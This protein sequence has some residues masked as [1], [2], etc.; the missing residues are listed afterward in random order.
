MSM[1]FYK[2]KNALSNSKINVQKIKENFSFISQHEKIRNINIK[3]KLKPAKLYSDRVRNYWV[4]DFK[5]KLG[6]KVKKFFPINPLRQIQ[7]ESSYN[8]IEKKENEPKTAVK[9][10]KNTAVKILGAINSLIKS[11]TRNKVDFIEMKNYLMKIETFKLILYKAE[12]SITVVSNVV[13]KISRTFANKIIKKFERHQD[14]ELNNEF[15]L[16]NRDL[17]S[18]LEKSYYERNKFLSSFIPTIA[19][20][21]MILESNKYG[22]INNFLKKPRAF[23][24]LFFVRNY[25]KEFFGNFKRIDKSTA[26]QMFSYANYQRLK[27]KRKFFTPFNLFSF[28]KNMTRRMF[29]KLALYAFAIIFIYNLIKFG[30][31]KIFV[32]RSDKDLKLALELVRDLKKQNEE[33]LKFNEKFLKKLEE[34]EK[35]I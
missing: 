27:E 5:T 32:K 30:L 13:K 25:I 12:T 10:I 23:Q 31:R 14:T 33:L 6:E 8:E 26:V 18:R 21:K 3:E 28:V 15:K 4:Y 35:R 17:S 7:S 19:S 1:Y 22:K 9:I 2:M 20:F 16:R 34:N 24:K 29:L 11:I